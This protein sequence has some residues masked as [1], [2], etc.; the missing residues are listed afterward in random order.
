MQEP[1]LN[2]R[3]QAHCLWGV[4]ELEKGLSGRGTGFEVLLKTL[5]IRKRLIKTSRPGGTP[6][7]QLLYA[8]AWNDFGCGLLEFAN[9]AEA[10]KYLEHA[11]ATKKRNTT[12]GVE[13]MRYAEGYMNLA[14]VRASQGKHEVAKNLV[15]EAARLAEKA[16]GPRSACSQNFTF[17]W[18]TILLLS[19]DLDA[20]RQK[21]HEIL[22]GRKKLFG[23]FALRTRHSYYALAVTYRKLGDLETAEY[24]K[25]QL[26][27]GEALTYPRDMCRLSLSQSWTSTHVLMSTWLDPSTT[28]PRYFE[29]STVLRQ[30]QNLRTAL[31]KS[32][33]SSC[34]N[35]RNPRM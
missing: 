33:K 16:N 17:Y 22:E 7:K 8:N 5:D 2:A 26:I 30:Q 13:P 12:K 11:L 21:H 20:A 18:A 34:R 4:I 28:S 3:A 35:M 9:Y 31:A 10:E 23:S 32:G 15:A 1:D 19:G 25:N 24:A 29:I 27:V 6:D 14:M